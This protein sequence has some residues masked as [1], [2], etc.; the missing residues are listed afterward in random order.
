MEHEPLNASVKEKKPRLFVVGLKQYF[1]SLKYYFTPLG[2]LFFFGAIGVAIFTRQMILS[3]QTFANEVT[4]L[5]KDAAISFHLD[6]FWNSLREN[7]IKMISEMSFSPDG[8]VDLVKTALR[9]AADPDHYQELLKALMQQLDNLT[10]SMFLSFLILMGFCIIG[11]FFGYVFIKI[12]LRSDA[13][14]HNPFKQ[15]GKFFLDG[16]SIVLLIFAIAKLYDKF[17]KSIYGTLPISFILVLFVSLLT[18][19][20]FYGK[21]SKKLGEIMNPYNILQ[22]VAVILISILLSGTI[23]YI[24]YKLAD[25]FL[26]LL[27]IMPLILT[28]YA[29]IGTTCEAYVIEVCRPAK[30]K[31]KAEKQ[32]LK[33]SEKQGK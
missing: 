3:L 17:P 14:N 16:A 21:G 28:T 29:F 9:S 18:S 1:K 20:L 2:T 26:V 11:V 32:S 31:L 4:S 24:I 7:G 10:K 30:E 12:A 8:F 15:I 22:Y 13:K 27:F 33:D 23:A 25:K 19:Y 5:A 6:A